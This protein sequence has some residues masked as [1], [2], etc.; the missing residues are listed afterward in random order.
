L[1]DSARETIG[2]ARSIFIRVFS[3]NERDR[4]NLIHYCNMGCANKLNHIRQKVIARFLECYDDPKHYRL[5]LTGLE[6]TRLP[7]KFPG[8]RHV[9]R[10][11]LTGNRF[12]VI[13]AFRGI[14]GLE[15]LILDGN[16]LSRSPS[17]EEL[18]GIE[19]SY[20]HNKGAARELSILGTLCNI[21][22]ETIP[23]GLPSSFVVRYVKRFLA[24][25]PD[26][27][28]SPNLKRALGSLYN[29]ADLDEELAIA[30][31]Q[32][33]ENLLILGGWHDHA[34][35]FHIQKVPARPIVNIS[36]FNAGDGCDYHT[37]LKGKVAY[38]NWPDVTL[39]KLKEVKMFRGLRLCTNRLRRSDAIT[40]YIPLLQHFFGIGCVPV[41]WI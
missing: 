37:H 16:R 29:I 2:K 20:L 8:L 32:R 11:D 31:L 38:V 40:R 24:K 27:L 25:Y 6:L 39:D 26:L 19:V 15:S 41:N 35:V 30:T 18:G 9:R 17:Q 5:D 12:E 34:V 14:P 28:L 22:D 23:V 1:P 3:Q 7:S 13:P 33:G 21:D 10:I 4:R 36:V